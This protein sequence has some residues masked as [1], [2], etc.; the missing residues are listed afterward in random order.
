M[1]FGDNLKKARIRKGLTQS[2][3]AE[4]LPMNQSNYS[5]LEKGIQEPSLNQLRRICSILEVSADQLLDLNI[6]SIRKK[7][8]DNFTKKITKLLEEY[9]KG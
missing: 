2:K 8:E 3:V 4:L 5:K 1:S 6:E 9:Y 7:R